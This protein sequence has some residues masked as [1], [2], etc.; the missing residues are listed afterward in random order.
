MEHVTI[1]LV[2]SVLCTA[3]AA[4]EI[5]DPSVA[6]T[7]IEVVAV[8]SETKPT[9]SPL[10]GADAKTVTKYVYEC[11]AEN[12][13]GDRATGIVILFERWVFARDLGEEVRLSDAD[14]LTDYAVRS[15][16]SKPST[17][18]PDRPHPTV[19]TFKGYIRTSPGPIPQDVG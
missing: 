13:K 6:S 18:W 2:A 10:T 14:T 1:V 19:C 12:E 17:H 8:V 3:C 5:P 7:P 15:F 4:E 11:T 9:K 16:E